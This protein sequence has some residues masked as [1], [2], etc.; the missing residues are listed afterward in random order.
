MKADRLHHSMMCSRVMFC[1]IISKICFAWLP[2]DSEL[3]LVDTVL[4]PAKMH[5][6]CS[7]VM[8]FDRASDNS[9]GHE[10]VHSD[11]SSWLWP[12]H[13]FQCD[14][15]WTS[16]LAVFEQPS[17]LSFGSGCHDIL[18]DVADNQDGSIESWFSLFVRIIAQEM[19]STD[20]GSGIPRSC[21]GP[22]AHP[23]GRRT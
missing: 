10:I 15:D 3:A 16:S 8:L 11:W 2:V 13:F 23:D 1:K 14:T 17:C 20:G 9:L 4:C 5:V 18:H 6:K 21:S 7:G 19:T 12:A 22:G